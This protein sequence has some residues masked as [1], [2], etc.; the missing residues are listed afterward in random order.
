[1]TTNSRAEQAR[2]DLLAAERDLA[3]AQA[4]VTRAREN[5]EASLKSYWAESHEPQAERTVIRFSL[6]LGGTLV[7]HYAGI[8]VDGR[9]YLTGGQQ[10]RVLDWKGVWHLIN[11]GEL[12]GGEAG[13]VVF[14]AAS[15]P[16]YDGC[17]EF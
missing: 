7:Y 10:N 8:K 3:L 11:Q 15:S 5:L 17:E 4:T 1:M 16:K 2:K 9:W 14:N 6:Q 12:V 13:F